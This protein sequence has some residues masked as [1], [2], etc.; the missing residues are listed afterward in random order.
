[1]KLSHNV[2]DIASIAREAEAAG[3]DALAVMNT[4]RG[5]AIDVEAGSGLVNVT[6][7]SPVRRFVR[8]RCSP[9]M[10]SRAR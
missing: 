5:M 4:V 9:C 2:T 3:A 10:R 7:G 6:G 8:L 1:M